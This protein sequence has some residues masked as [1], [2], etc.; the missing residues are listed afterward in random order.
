[1]IQFYAPEIADTL[2]LPESD[3]AHAVRV[4]RMKSGDPL[5]V[6]DG[7]GNVYQCR[8][9]EA[10][11]KRA[12][13]EIIS[14][15]TQPLPWSQ[16]IVVAVAPTKHL[17]RMEW[18]VEKLTEIGVNRIIP[19]LCAR[20]ERKEIKTERL[21]KIAVSAMKQSL[22]AV[23][24]VIDEM[25]PIHKITGDFDGYTKAIAYCDDT[26]ELKDF[27][28]L[29]RPGGNTIILIGPEGDF[30]PA[31]I[32]L[33]LGAGFSAVTLG[34]N[35]LRTETAALYAVSACHIIDQINHI[36]I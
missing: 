34:K 24:P 21:E 6:I 17:D 32:E 1:M 7:R 19:M 22:K 26:V 35:R 2:R 28:S 5:Q 12:A 23:L 15:D 18:M 31:E 14:C 25:T 11:S 30:S 9:T 29:Y 33:T 36:N 8:M 4:L 13:V 3:S 20:S 16:Q 10:H 27:T